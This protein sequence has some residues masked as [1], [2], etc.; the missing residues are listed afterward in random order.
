MIDRQ[1]MLLRRELWEHKALYLTPLVV[2]GVLVFGFLLSFLTGIFRGAPLDIAVATLQISGEA[3]TL[4]GVGTL[5]AVPSGLFNLSLSIV[6]FFYCLDALYSERKDRSILFWRSLPV[7][8]TEAVL[9][10]LATAMF[11]AP[12]ITAVVTIATQ[13][14]ILIL[15]SLAVLIGD[16]NP[17]ELIWAPLPF[18]QAWIL[19]VY[20]LMTSSL[21]LAPF[22]GWILLCSSFAKRSVLVW[23]F[24]PIVFV[25]LLQSIVFTDIGI[26]R[27]LTERL[28]MAA[29]VGFELPTGD[30]GAM[31]HKLMASGDPNLLALAAPL[32]FLTQPG[33]WAGFAVTALFIAGA[34]YFRRYRE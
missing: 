15:A 29:I 3:G 21:W 25:V 22:A 4:T 19:L 2:A 10:K 17:I 12:L 18:V 8:D 26:A 7:T 13:L 24:L 1:V 27:M 34:V 14:V 11:V 9:A 32:K 31:L 28:A 16:G 5:L 30:V 23:T 20:V 33:L 6:V